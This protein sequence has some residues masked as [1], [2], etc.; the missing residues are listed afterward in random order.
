MGLSAA[1]VPL[2][3][4]QFQLHWIPGYKVRSFPL[5]AQLWTPAASL[6]LVLGEHQVRDTCACAQESLGSSSVHTEDW[7]DQ[8]E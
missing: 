7:K 5:G 4:K 2:L 1:L 8:G 3:S 6:R